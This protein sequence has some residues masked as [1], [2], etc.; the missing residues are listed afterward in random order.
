MKYFDQVLQALMGGILCAIIWW[1]MDRY[2][3]QDQH[4]FNHYWTVVLAYVA[5][6][7][8]LRRG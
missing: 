8:P 7:G 5:G 2:L 3:F 6:F 1:L 4:D